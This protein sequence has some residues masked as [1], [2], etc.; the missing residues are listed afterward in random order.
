MARGRA[1]KVAPPA[2]AQRGLDVRRYKTRKRLKRTNAANRKVRWEVFRMVKVAIRLLAWLR[3]PVSLESVSEATGFLAQ[4]MQGFRRIPEKTIWHSD[5]C[6]CIFEGWKTTEAP[7]RSVARPKVVIP[8]SLKEKSAAQL[9]VMVVV[10]QEALR[11][12]EMGRMQA[13]AAQR[14]E[15]TQSGLARRLAEL[16]AAANALAEGGLATGEPEAA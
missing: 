14:R 7:K 11:V 8:R 4:G 1:R 13:I 3:L 16:A 9:R 10:L 15:R 12:S 5:A 6:S 2:P